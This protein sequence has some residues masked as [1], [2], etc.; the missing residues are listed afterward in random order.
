VKQL[1]QMHDLNDHRY[2]SSE[3]QRVDN[4]PQNRPP[5]AVAMEWV[6]RILAVVFVMIGPGI[7]GGWLDKRWGTGFLT[8][9]GFA[10]GLTVGTVYLV[11][12]AKPR[13]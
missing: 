6:S 2:L 7:L 8:L 9:S 11:V 10:V 5:M 12:V 1:A 13:K 4:S 3:R